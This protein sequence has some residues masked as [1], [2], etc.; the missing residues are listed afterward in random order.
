MC[1]GSLNILSGQE[2][3]WLPEFPSDEELEKILQSNTTG[4]NSNNKIDK[5]TY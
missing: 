5:E 1:S 2:C 3:L 4:I